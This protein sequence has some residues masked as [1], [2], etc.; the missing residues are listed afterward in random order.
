MSKTHNYFTIQYFPFIF[1]HNRELI[2]VI[3]LTHKALINPNSAI[4][5]NGGTVQDDVTIPAFQ[6]SIAV[7]DGII[8]QLFGRRVTNAAASQ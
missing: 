8:E 6:V 1:F 2:Y 5:R 4:K 7:L 3:S